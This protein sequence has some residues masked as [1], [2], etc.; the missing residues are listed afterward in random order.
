MRERRLGDHW[1]RADRECSTG[2]KTNGL[3][4]AGETARPGPRPGD[5]GETEECRTRPEP[6]P[7]DHGETGRSA[8]S[9]RTKSSGS[10]GAHRQ[11]RKTGGD[12]GRTVG[13]RMLRTVC[14]ITNT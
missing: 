7:E 2:T 6:K 14:S 8:S 11:K 9:T 5:H 1:E 12:R 3:P 4:G 10:L 13:T